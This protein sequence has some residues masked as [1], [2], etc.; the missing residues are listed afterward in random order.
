MFC[1]CTKSYL[2]MI[3]FRARRGDQ[4]RASY[5][6]LYWRMLHQMCGKCADPPGS[7]QFFL[8]ADLGPP[9]QI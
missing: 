6:S 5:K 9:Y 3:Y 1:R 4:L 7:D 2:G 8:K